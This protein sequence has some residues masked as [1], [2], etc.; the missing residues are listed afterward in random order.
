MACRECLHYNCE[1]RVENPHQQGAEGERL[2]LGATEKQICLFFQKSYLQ[3]GFYLSFLLL[4]SYGYRHI[5]N[6]KGH[7]HN[8]TQF[9]S[10]SSFH[11]LLKSIITRYIREIWNKITRS[12]LLSQVRKCR[13][14]TEI[15]SFIFRLKRK[16]RNL[17]IPNLLLFSEFEFDNMAVSNPTS[18]IECVFCKK[19]QSLYKWHLS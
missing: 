2:H 16:Q 14:S 9:S 15:L 12:Q 18:V 8:V 6:K 19:K 13:D 7:K 4:A 5:T 1:L 10:K 17:N 11:N 3:L